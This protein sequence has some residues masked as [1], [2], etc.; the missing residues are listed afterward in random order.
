[1]TL[2]KNSTWHSS[3]P[4]ISEP[5]AVAAILRDG[6]LRIGQFDEYLQALAEKADLHLPHLNR[7]AKYGFVFQEG[8]THLEARRRIAPFFSARAMAAWEPVA[9]RAIGSAIE[10]LAASETP[11]LVRDF[12]SPA[13]I[14]FVRPFFGLDGGEDGKLLDLIQT[15]NAVTT[16]LL[17]L[18][19]LRAIEDA[20]KELAGHFPVH[21]ADHP[22]S[23]L[24]F[25]A[26][27]GAPGK[28]S[29]EPLD[30]ALST[31]IASHTLTQSL[32]YILY[33]M[34]LGELSSW[35]AAS[36]Q[37]WVEEMLDQLIALYPSTLSL[38][39]VAK[40]DVK[41][42]GC[43]FH[44]GDAA[45]L[46]V[47]AA[48]R[49]LAVTDE[50][51]PRQ[52]HLAFG[53]GPHKCPGELLSRFFLGLA[54]PALAK[55]FP[56][57]AMQRDKVAF[58]VSPLVQYPLSMPCTLNNRSQRLNARMVEI[59]NQ[60]EARRIVAD[61]STWAPP[62]ME[63]YLQAVAQ[64]S[65]KDMSTALRIARNAMFFMSGP[66]HS[67]IRLA[68]ANCLGGNK[69][70]HW[71]PLI[72]T[73][74]IQALDRLTGSGEADL[75]RDFS[76]PLFR[77][78]AQPILGVRPGDQHRFDALA[79]KLQ[80]VLEPWLPLRQLHELQDCFAEL[81]A[82]IDETPVSKLPAGCL[83]DDLISADLPSFD[84]AELK[85]FILVLYGASFNLSH[86]L[87]NILHYGLTLPAPQR[88]QLADPG[89]VTQ[90]LESLISLCASPKYIY[91]MARK[92]AQA[93]ELPV[94][95]NETLRLQL[96]QINRGFGT[97]HLAFGHGLH[98]CIGA[99][100]TKEVLQA[101][102]PRFFATFPDAAL[103]AQ[104]HQYRDMTETVAL[105]SLRCRLGIA[106][107]KD[108]E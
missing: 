27:N 68:A 97:G 25:L 39:R 99:A 9:Q 51:A 87:G 10:K 4:L 11:D 33:A 31:L 105:E 16:P 7:L 95:Q 44:S 83:L 59:R 20:T 64:R 58:H 74:T 15:A 82:L 35:Q 73:Q 84:A 80:D 89:W 78:I 17:P 26:N 67:E 2:P 62:Q 66:R 98:R 45:R 93:G 32:S 90:N 1:M 14:G 91:R 103:T 88:R 36:R 101:A 5:K 30:M 100:L 49:K 8:A 106:E 24:A 102:L 3:E 13:F 22:D 61:D 104:N 92:P 43:P 21:P 37:G 34:L 41:L 85:A 65:Q 94:G 57:L 107:T 60:E 52:K 6:R 29:G 23:F 79:P 76:E 54:I 12:C 81:T 38:V 63:P 86:T 96:L 72:E 50:E 48:N 108:N 77:G 28:K 47:I 70:R 71:R 19:S 56:R 69:I 46:D 40:E 18:R 75:I 42:Q 55:S 53:H